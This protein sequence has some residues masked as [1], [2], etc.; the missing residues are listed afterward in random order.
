MPRSERLRPPCL[1]LIAGQDQRKELVIVERETMIVA[2][3]SS[4]PSWGHGFQVPGLITKFIFVSGSF[5]F[6][7]NLFTSLSM[8]EE[9]GRERTHSMNFETE[10]TSEL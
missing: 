8:L 6:F 9:E 2:F 10:L 1:F 7:F 3:E 5:F 4:Q